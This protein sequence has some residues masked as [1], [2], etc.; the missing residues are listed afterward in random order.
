MAYPHI[1]IML[2]YKVGGKDIKPLYI[3]YNS[4]FFSLQRLLKV[5]NK[6]D[7]TLTTDSLLKL[8]SY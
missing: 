4:N 3:L 5:L 2:S 8:Q 6:C 1:R 7:S